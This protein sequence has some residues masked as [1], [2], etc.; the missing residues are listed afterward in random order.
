MC[1]DGWTK[2]SLTPFWPSL[3][4]LY[5][6][7]TPSLRRSRVSPVPFADED[8]GSRPVAGGFNTELSE[9]DA[10]NIMWDPKAAEYRVYHKTWID[11]GAGVMFWKRA[12]MVH[13]R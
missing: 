6:V 12:V 9:S 7:F 3:R 2:G 1:G 10:M 4:R 5:A 11:S 13:T 8:P